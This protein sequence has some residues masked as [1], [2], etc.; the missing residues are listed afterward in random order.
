MDRPEEPRAMPAHFQ[1]MQVRVPQA[2]VGA[3][4]GKLSRIGSNVRSLDPTEPLH[5]IYADLP[6]PE[7]LDFEL[8][9]DQN[10]DGQ[11][12]LDADESANDAQAWTP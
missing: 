7:V 1:K 10:S 3:V 5:T 8:W 6:L 11:G 12:R 4:I 9:L 2:C